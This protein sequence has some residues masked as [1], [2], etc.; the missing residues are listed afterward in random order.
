MRPFAEPAPRRGWGTVLALI[1][2]VVGVI[3]VGV[4][5][6]RDQIFGATP[7]PKAPTHERK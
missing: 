7:G 5:L 4:V 1:L 3:G 6:F 2:V